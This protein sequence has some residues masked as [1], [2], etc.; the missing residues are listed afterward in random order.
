MRSGLA[1]GFS[2]PRATLNGRDQSI[3]TFIV[4]DSAKSS[5]YKPFEH[6]P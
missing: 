3:A 5:F 2:V 4:D 6:F 1:R